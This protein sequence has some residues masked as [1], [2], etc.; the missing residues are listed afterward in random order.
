VT[1]SNTSRTFGSKSLPRIYIHPALN[2]YRAYLDAITQSHFRKRKAEYC[3]ANFISQYLSLQ[4][5]RCLRVVPHPEI[6]FPI[7]RLLWLCYDCLWLK[8]HFMTNPATST[9]FL[10]YGVMLHLQDG[11]LQ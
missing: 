5:C 6:L 4:L 7:D 8:P 9:R 2:H 10:V 1:Y 3:E 11:P